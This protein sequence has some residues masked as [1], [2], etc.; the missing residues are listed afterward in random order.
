MKML[1]AYAAVVTLLVFAAV[2]S[3][4]F[5]SDTLPPNHHVH[6][7]LAAPG[8]YPHLGGRLLPDYPPRIARRL[9]ARPGR[10][11]RRNRQG[12]APSERGNWDANA[13]RA[14]ARGC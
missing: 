8:V 6:D 12:A 13:E 14:A 7:C 3:A 11:Q 9:S 10:L 2:A 5:T 1:L 4:Q